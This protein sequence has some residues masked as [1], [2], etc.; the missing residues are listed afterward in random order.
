MNAFYCDTSA[1]GI[2]QAISFLGLPGGKLWEKSFS[3][4][5]PKMCEL[6]ASVVNGLLKRSLEVE[7]TTAICEKLINEKY[8]EEQIKKETQGFFAGDNEKH[9]LHN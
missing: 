9:S 7:I 1:T 3:N 6:I 8:S 5:S 2:D 4:Y